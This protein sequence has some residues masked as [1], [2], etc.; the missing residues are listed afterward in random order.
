MAAA[1]AAST[2]MD[3]IQYAHPFLVWWG[4]G[5]EV[6]DIIKGERVECIG[7]GLEVAVVFVQ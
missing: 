7:V 1:A 6:S 2:Q 5:K 4:W 3:T